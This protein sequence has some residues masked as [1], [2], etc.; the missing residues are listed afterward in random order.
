MSQGYLLTSVAPTYPETPDTCHC[1]ESR[2]ASMYAATNLVHQ[3][4]TESSCQYCRGSYDTQKT[5]YAGMVY[6]NSY[7]YNTVSQTLQRFI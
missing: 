1:S 3:W 2:G 4:S 6:G 5:P 7:C